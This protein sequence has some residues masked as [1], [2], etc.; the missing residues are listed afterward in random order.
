MKGVRKRSF[1][2]ERSFLVGGKQ[3]YRIWFRHAFSLSVCSLLLKSKAARNALS[4]FLKIRWIVGAGIYS[5]GA[6]GLGISARMRISSFDQS[7]T[8][9]FAVSRSTPSRISLWPLG[10][11]GRCF[12]VPRGSCSYSFPRSAKVSFNA[13]SK[14]RLLPRDLTRISPL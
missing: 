1:T 8:P 11:K 7:T 14:A 4:C 5:P 10:S 2:K 6:S 12:P 9:S 13:C 3:R